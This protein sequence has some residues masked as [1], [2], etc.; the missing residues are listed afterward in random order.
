MVFR[1]CLD[2]ISP[3][4]CP[5]AGLKTVCNLNP[6]SY[7]KYKARD[8]ALL[9]YLS[10]VGDILKLYPDRLRR[11]QKFEAINN[12]E[13]LKILEGWRREE[14]PA[15]TKISPIPY[16]TTY[17]EDPLDRVEAFNSLFGVHQL[18]IADHLFIFQPYLCVNICPSTLILVTPFPIC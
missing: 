17:Q 9:F 1:K 10:R 6:A 8:F 15:F 14:T 13:K 18:A 5:P 3:N 16:Q 2:L 7:E 4:H 12:S 11:K